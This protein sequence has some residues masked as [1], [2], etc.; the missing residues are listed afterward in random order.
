MSETKIQ[1]LEG[2]IRELELVILEHLKKTHN[3]EDAG[4]DDDCSRGF[5][6]SLLQEDDE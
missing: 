5:M 6:F 4:Y 1:E 2:R 3:I